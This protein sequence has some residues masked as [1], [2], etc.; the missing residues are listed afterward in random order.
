LSRVEIATGTIN[1]LKMNLAAKRQ[2]IEDVDYMTAITD[3]KEAEYAFEATKQISGAM[4]KPT[5]LNYIR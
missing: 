5:L 3:F 1:S 2:N 4:F